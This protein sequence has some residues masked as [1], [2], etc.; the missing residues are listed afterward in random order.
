MRYRIAAF[1][2]ILFMLCQIG[3]SALAESIELDQEQ[4]IYEE[5][6]DVVAEENPECSEKF[7]IVDEVFPEESQPT[8][9]CAGNGIYDG[10]TEWFD[11]CENEDLLNGFVEQKLNRERGLLQSSF[12]AGRRL[13]SSEPGQ[14][15]VYFL[16]KV[17]VENVA[18]GERTL[19]VFSGPVSDLTDYGLIEKTKYYTADL[20]Y[21][22]VDDS[23][24][25]EVAAAMLEQMNLKG[26]TSAMRALLSD[27]PYELYWFD[28]TS[29]G[30]YNYSFQYEYN[31]DKSGAYTIELTGYTIR[32]AAAQ[33]YAVEKYEVTTEYADAVNAAIRNAREI[34]EAAGDY[35]DVG[36]LEYYLEQICILASYNTAAAH[37]GLPYGDPWQIIYVFDGDPSTKVVCEGYA[38]AFAY[39][40]ELSR[41]SEA[42]EWYT[43]SGKTTEN[44]MWNILS[45]NGNNFLVDP[46]NCD[47]GAIGQGKQLFLV[48][49]DEG[50]VDEGYTF[51]CRSGSISYR[52][53]SGTLAAFDKADLNLVPRGTDPRAPVKN[54]LTL[55]GDGVWRYYDRNIFVPFTGIVDY[56]GR[57]FFVAEGLLCSKA[58]GLNCFEDTWYF[59]S[60]GQI[61]DQYTGLALYDGEWFYV[62][63]GILNTGMQGLLDYDG[64]RFLVS[65]GQ[66]RRDVNGLWQNDSRTQVGGD[67]YWYYLAKGEVQ[68]KY[69][70]L[71]EYDGAWFYVVNGRLAVEYTGTVVYDGQE[72]YVV[73]GQV[74]F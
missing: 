20:G 32:L 36:K 28:K 49:Y 19:T 3:F 48:G 26:I 29:A 60:G 14:A 59:L 23:N 46:T 65:T 45:L 21:E 40:C 57:R 18:N 64:G 50:S 58:K 54:G 73:N 30:G 33:K 53:D 13:V 16:L 12:Y 24:K 69:T 2:L 35:T 55:D 51:R 56:G 38:K 70:G 74:V 37:G 7:E 44:H 34:A 41:F 62:V 42:V 22:T 11:G 17:E 8:E 15:S 6:L 27:C 61:Q 10:P 68:T 66:I 47:D 71:A 5:S 4:E 25:R 52:Y 39:L 9:S 43:V 31:Q 63:D 72:F 67:D 1:I